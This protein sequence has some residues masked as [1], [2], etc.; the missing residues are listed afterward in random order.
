MMRKQIDNWEQ[1]KTRCRRVL[2]ANLPD[3]DVLGRLNYRYTCP[4]KEKGHYLPQWLW[5]SC[6]HALTY[7]WF[8]P[9]MA[10]DE[11][12][13]LFVHQVFEGDDKGMVPHMAHFA[14]NHDEVDQLLFR[15]PNRSML[16]QPPLIAI[17]AL[18]V[19]E[20]APARTILTS[21][22]PK[23]KLYHDWFDRRRDPDGDHL[24]TIIHPWE[25]GWDAA[26][27]WDEMMGVTETTSTQLAALGD[28]RKKLVELIFEH[29]C[30]ANALARVNGSF[31]VEPADLNAIR[32][33]DL[34]ALARIAQEI[35]QS[36]Q[37]QNELKL[38]AEAVRQ[39]IRKKMIRID[40][41]RLYAHDLI[42][43]DEKETSPDSA[44]KFILMF[45]KCVNEDEAQLLRNELEEE[46]SRFN[47]KY[48]IP[49]TPADNASFDGGEYWRGNVWLAINWLVYRGLQ[50]YGFASEAQ[51]LAQKSLE[52]VDHSGF[53]EF[54]N[55]ITGDRGKRL[56]KLCPQNQSWS[57]I[58]LDMLGR[59]RDSD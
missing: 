42:G 7:R 24:V 51:R 35:G 19:Y 4:A 13:S 39:A 58:V 30:D 56:G 31:F 10:W 12:Q 17:A 29:H 33:A 18:A 55:P 25:S 34:E 50:N 37:E 41:G 45:G 20:K 8:E 11:L 46:V 14:E 9:D 22:Y 52:L 44:A 53:C 3:R 23:L 15:H 27:R 36:D 54:Y 47:T 28:K 2:E 26:Q 1:W 21:M 5:D 32:A 43:P 49:T 59:E 38:R 48:P 40:N 57:T 6:F 16:T